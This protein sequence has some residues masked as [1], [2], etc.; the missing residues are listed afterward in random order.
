MS[1]ERLEEILE[2]MCIAYQCHIES[3]TIKGSETHFK[4]C[5]DYQSMVLSQFE[6][7]GERV[8][9]LERK[10]RVDSELFDKQ[11]QQNKRQCEAISN[12]LVGLTQINLISREGEQI[13]KVLKDLE[14]ALKDESSE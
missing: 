1:K 6:K 5:L 3:N 2:L 10:V 8:Q 13:K 9:E 11:V 4:V 14:K 12:A 7:K